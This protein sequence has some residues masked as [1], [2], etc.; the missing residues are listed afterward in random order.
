MPD[1][2]GDAGDLLAYRLVA[3]QLVPRHLGPWLIEVRD[4]Q[5][6]LVLPLGVS[7]QAL[8]PLPVP[9]LVGGEL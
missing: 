7:V 6:W 9:G 3:G 1:P 5:G 4:G 2:Y 8:S